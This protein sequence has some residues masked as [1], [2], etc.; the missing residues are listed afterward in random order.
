MV[1][2]V[3]DDNTGQ[4]DA[5]ASRWQRFEHPY[6]EAADDL[7]CVDILNLISIPSRGNRTSHRYKPGRAPPRFC[8]QLI[9]RIGGPS[10]V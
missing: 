4:H 9:A 5:G 2:D 1:L 6:P 7:P 10:N 8:V 3:I